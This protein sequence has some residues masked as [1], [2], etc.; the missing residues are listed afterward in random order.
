MSWTF[1]C[2][3]RTM[4]LRFAIYRF[5]YLFDQNRVYFLWKKNIFIVCIDLTIVYKQIR[6]NFISWLNHF[7]HNSDCVAHLVIYPTTILFIRPPKLFFLSHSLC[8]GFIIVY[9]S[10]CFVFIKLHF[11]NEI[12]LWSQMSLS[13]FYNL[14]VLIILLVLWIRMTVSMWYTQC[15]FFLVMVYVTI[16]MCGS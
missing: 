8:W 7:I 9:A 14:L 4:Q 2:M 6:K 13:L 15:I 10:I 12:L 1:S 16:T 3:L 11:K 5:Y